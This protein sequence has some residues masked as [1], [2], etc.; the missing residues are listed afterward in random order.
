MT[1]FLDTIISKSNLYHR[2]DRETLVF[3]GRL[4]D[5]FSEF[6]SRKLSVKD[7]RLYLNGH[8]KTYYQVTCIDSEVSTRLLLS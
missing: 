3:H 5:V 4:V 1:F 8:S 7:L 2:W 6:F